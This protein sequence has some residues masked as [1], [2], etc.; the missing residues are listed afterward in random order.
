MCG[1]EPV[2]NADPNMLTRESLHALIMDVRKVAGNQFMSAPGGSFHEAS[3]RTTM[4]ALADLESKLAAM[5]FPAKAEPVDFLTE[6][7]RDRVLG[8]LGD[9]GEDVPVVLMAHRLDTALIELYSESRSGSNLEEVADKLSDLSGRLLERLEK[10]ED[11]TNQDTPIKI[12]IDLKIN[13]QRV[14]LGG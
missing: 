5:R 3:A 8:D 13:G 1:K 4:N 7:T 14:G 10:E 6:R 11:P 12:E 2:A 9:L